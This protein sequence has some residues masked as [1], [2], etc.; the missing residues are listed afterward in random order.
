[1]PED[2]TMQSPGRDPNSLVGK[3]IGHYQLESLIGSGHMSD[4]Y[5]ARQKAKNRVITLKVFKP[6]TVQEYPDLFLREAK[7]L[8]GLKHPHIVRVF[9]A[10]T[11][12]RY[13]FLVMEFM[14]NGS[15]RDALSDNKAAIDFVITTAVHTL[16]GLEFLHNKGI[17]HRNLKLENL[18]VDGE[19]SVKISDYGIVRLME[20]TNVITP[21]HHGGT[22]GYVSPEQLR[23]D[24]ISEATDLYSLG[25]VLYRMTSGNRPYTGKGVREVLRQV[26]GAPPPKLQQVRPEVPDFLAAFIEHLLKPDPDDRFGSAQAALRSLEAQV[27]RF[28]AKAKAASVSVDPQP[29]QAESRPAQ[30]VTESPAK[31][32]A[33]PAKA[34]DRTARQHTVLPIFVCPK[35]G[36]SFPTGRLYRF[37]CPH[38]DCRHFWKTQNATDWRPLASDPRITEPVLV[39]TKGLDKGATFEIPEGDSALG[40]HTEASVK[41]TDAKVAQRHAT[42]TRKGDSIVLKAA[43]N[44]TGLLVNVRPTETTELH[45][46]DTIAVGNTVL[47]LKR[48][49]LPRSMRE[50]QRRKMLWAG[51]EG[52][53]VMQIDGKSGHRFV[54]RKQ[55]TSIGRSS[56]QDVR[57]MHSLVSRRHATILDDAEG[58]TLSD[59]RSKTGVFVN[60]RR[61][62]KAT[63]KKYD[64]LQIGPFL[65]VFDGTHFKCKDILKALREK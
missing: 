39:V 28:Q 11:A 60:G 15:L 7:I 19:G 44:Q 8:T 56:G 16:K 37:Y 26:R 21:G 4:V 20:A 1:M 58:L 55:Q 51:K 17:I 24:P 46:G 47:T 40:R 64:E 57:L 59:L 52:A 32:V 62:L 42:L 27:R 35:C 25:A 12:V 65:I 14:E 9:D 53:L 38:P 41:L 18:L 36:T 30:S 5:R 3:T 6:A 45:E 22:L 43:Y 50:Y 29:G 34:E 13:C 31:A 23:G 2:V 33:P 49:E 61:I 54:V 48:R 63:L 10:A